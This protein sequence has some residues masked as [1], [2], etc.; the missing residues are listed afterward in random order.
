M[1]AIGDTT[2]ITRG[3]FSLSGLDSVLSGSLHNLT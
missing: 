3:F 1:V 2:G